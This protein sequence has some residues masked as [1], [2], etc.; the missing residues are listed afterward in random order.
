M[1]LLGVRRPPAWLFA[2]IGVVV[3]GGFAF[4]TFKIWSNDNALTDRGQ[5]AQAR[6][7]AVDQGRAGRTRVEFQTGDRQ[8]VQALIGQGDSGPDLKVGD[9][10]RIVYDP[11][12]PAADVRDVRVEANH[13]LAYLTLGITIVGAIAVPLVVWR[14][15][16][17]KAWK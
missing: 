17:E 13:T 8:Q 7:V 6:V 3:V 5:Q 12:D 15:R 2:L 9:D 10:V 16:R 4:I 1:K 11:Q 14:L